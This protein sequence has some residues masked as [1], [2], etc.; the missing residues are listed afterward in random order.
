MGPAIVMLRC[1]GSH[2]RPASADCSVQLCFAGAL[3]HYK[4]E[5]TTSTGQQQAPGVA[6]AAAAAA[7]AAMGPGL[8]TGINGVGLNNMFFWQQTT[9]AAMDF[10]WVMPDPLFAAGSAHGVDMRFCATQQVPTPSMGT[11]PPN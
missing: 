2:C 4:H 3:R 10:S 11:A 7:A 9:D 8:S 6:A 1:R 5:L